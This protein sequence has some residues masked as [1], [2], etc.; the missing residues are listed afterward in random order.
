MQ[1][2][3]SCH[4]VLRPSS[5][6]RG[7]RSWRTQALPHGLLDLRVL[8]GLR[9]LRSLRGLGPGERI[10]AGDPEQDAPRGA[11]DAGTRGLD[12]TGVSKSVDDHSRLAD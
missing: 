10:A 7:S 2:A 9:S 3:A 11:R 6:F 5:P 12:S 1:H 4:G 8:R